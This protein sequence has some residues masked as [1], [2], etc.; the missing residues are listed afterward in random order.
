MEP[1]VNP[2]EDLL[3]KL[4]SNTENPE[5]FIRKEIIVLVSRRKKKVVT[6]LFMGIIVVN[7][8]IFSAK[9]LIWREKSVQSPKCQVNV[10]RGCL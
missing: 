6:S 3:K 8:F 7:T 5:E 10:V 4:T 9:A 1:S 2:V